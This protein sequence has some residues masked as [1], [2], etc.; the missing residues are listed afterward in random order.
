MFVLLTNRQKGSF[1]HIQ[2][3]HW[4]TCFLMLVAYQLRFVPSYRTTPAGRFAVSRSQS[5]N[6]QQSTFPQLTELISPSLR[7]CLIILCRDRIQDNSLVFKLQSC[8]DTV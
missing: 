4:D 2:P 6:K 8:C 5:D 3:A 1:L 7:V